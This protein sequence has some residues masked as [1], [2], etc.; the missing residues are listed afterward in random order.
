MAFI[1]D[2][3]FSLSN[4]V[5]FG[6]LASSLSPSEAVALVDK[7][8]ILVDSAFSVAGIYI[9]D[10]TAD[11]CMA[12]TGLVESPTA[13]SVKTVTSSQ[14]EISGL[15]SRPST[16]NSAQ[17]TSLVSEDAGYETRESDDDQVLQAVGQEAQEM[18]RGPAKSKGKDARTVVGSWS[19]ILPPMSS[20]SH[21]HQRNK[22]CHVCL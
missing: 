20:G 15:Y 7:L 21:T 22:V 5:G 8:H 2:C 10:Q 12:V 13:E 3:R 6:R 11:A 1:F 19:P 9:I 16:R 18:R 4:V 17:V 14:R